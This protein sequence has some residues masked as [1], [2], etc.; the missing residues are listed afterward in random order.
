MGTISSKDCAPI[1]LLLYR[2]Q[3]SVKVKTAV[4]MQQRF[5]HFHPRA[6]HSRLQISLWAKEDEDCRVIYQILKGLVRFGC[7]TKLHV[8]LTTTGALCLTAH[9]FEMQGLNQVLGSLTRKQF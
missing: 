5:P 3:D 9:L 6:P 2:K 4:Y 1:A 8:S 7:V